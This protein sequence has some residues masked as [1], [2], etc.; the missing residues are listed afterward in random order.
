MG[1]KTFNLLRGNIDNVRAINPPVYVVDNTCF[2]AFFVK[3]SSFAFSTEMLQNVIH[4]NEASQDRYLMVLDWAIGSETCE[5]ARRKM[6]T[7]ACKDNSYCY[8]S[9]NGVGY[10]CNC[11]AGYDGNLYSEDGCKDIDE[12]QDPERNPYVGRCI[13]KPGSFS[14]ACALGQR[15]D[16]RKNETGCMNVV[17]LEL[18]FGNI[19]KSAY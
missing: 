11:N 6:G 1:L 17:S 7:Y 13:N 2:Q 18:I 9:T 3:K 4:G 16:G 8:N 12:C 14:C 19:L 5:E 15:G 10:R